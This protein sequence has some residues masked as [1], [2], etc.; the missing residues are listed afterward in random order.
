MPHDKKIIDF[1]QKVEEEQTKGVKIRYPSL[2]DEAVKRYSKVTVKPGRKYTKVDIGT[3]GYFMVD[4][5][6]NIFGIK[7][8]GV[9]NKKK[10]YGTLDTINEW[11]WG[12]Y[13]PKKIL[14]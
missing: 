7:G 6:G 13:V 8:Y 10:Q 12:G 5:N 4:E 3:S 2:N 9:V 14:F 1:S 11:Y